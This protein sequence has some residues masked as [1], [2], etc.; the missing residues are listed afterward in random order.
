MLDFAKF[1]R[2]LTREGNIYFIG[3]GGIS[4]SSLAMISLRRGLRVGGSDRTP[5]ALTE[6]LSRAGAEVFCGHSAEN[7]RSYTVFVYNAAIPKDNPEY[8]YGEKHGAALL[9]RAEYLSYLTAGFTHSVGVSGTHGK[10]TTTAMIARVMDGCDCDPTVLNGAVI[11]E[12]GSAYRVG[13]NDYLAFEACEYK[14]SFL[15]FHPSL[16]VILNIELDHVDYFKDTDAIIASFRRYLAGSGGT[17]VIN[18]DD[19]NARRAAESF[20]GEV[21]SYGI[22]AEDAR[23]AVRNLTTEDG[24]PRFDVYADGAFYAHVR[25]SVAGAHNVSNAAA[26]LAT[27]Y[28]LGLPGE[29]AGAALSGFTGTARRFERVGNLRGDGA[30]VYSDYAHHPTEIRATVSAAKAVCKGRLF[31]VFQ[32]HTYTRTKALFSDFAAAFAGCDTVLFADIYAARETDTLGVSSAQLAGATTNGVYAGSFDAAA[33][34][35]LKHAEKNDLVLIM[36][37]GDIERIIPL[38]K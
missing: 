22:T 38:L 28:A 24:Y 35:L 13:K 36:G 32:P 9:S 27:A 18:F 23:V 21:F 2:I 11:P 4:M 16:P 33:D 19:A 8:V 30:A 37:A 1:D 5:S 10:S 14:D 25:L 34:Y 6:A 17:A 7:V 31:T 15:S 29:A 3:I 20:S 26:A 12:Y